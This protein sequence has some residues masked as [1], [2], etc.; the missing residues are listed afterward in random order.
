MENQMKKILSLIL[1][2][3]LLCGALLGLTSC[4][5]PKDDG[6]EIVVDLGGEVYDFDPTDYYAD[7]NAE[8]IMTLLF[9]P[10]F[11]INSKGKLVCAAAKDYSVDREE[12]KIKITLRESYWS[13]ETPVLASDYIYAWREVLLESSKPNPAAALLYDIENAVALKAGDVTYSEFGAVSTGAFEL[14]ITYREGADYKQLLK[15][16]ASVATSPLRQSV[17]EASPTYWTKDVSTIVTNGPFQIQTY[18]PELGEFTLARNLGYHQKTTA[19][20]YTDKVTPAKLISFT[21]D[22]TD[23]VL[24]YDDIVNKTVFYMGDASLEDRAANKAKAKSTDALSAYTY[25]FN[26]EK[27]IFKD[28][29]VR[30]ALSLA[31]DRAAIAEAVTFGKA[32]TGFLPDV[33][34]KSVWGKSIPERISSNYDERL[35]T[36]K[37]LIAASSLTAAEK[38]FTLTV[39]YDDESIAIANLAK[40]AWAELGFKVTVKTVSTVSTKITDTTLEE[41]KTIID[42][43]IQALIKEASYG[44]RDFDVIAVDWNMYSKDPIVALSAFTSH[45]NGNGTDLETGK[46]RLNISGWSSMDYDQYINKAF[47]AKTDEERNEALIA[48]EKL[49]LEEAPVIPVLYNQNFAF[50]SSDLSSVS[51]DGLGHFV[52]TKVKQKNYEK[53]LPKED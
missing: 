29:D 45:M 14:T 28:A 16:L 31:L 12:R 52:L 37:D 26:T 42:S 44:K 50:V 22:D 5:E 9:E 43:S 7:S 33:I 25:V 3:S 13:D 39:N 20:K 48:A 30:R 36:A 53:Y 2:A 8:Q 27:E 17:V 10:L 4:G 41:E 34:A 19:K 11:K 32:A 23:Y 46:S 38:A 49:L 21:A 1:A 47:R 15:N 40:E 51:I 24:S 6:A 18:N 35:E